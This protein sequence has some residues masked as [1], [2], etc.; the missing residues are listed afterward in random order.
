MTAVLATTLPEVE[1]TASRLTD[2]TGLVLR[3]QGTD[4]GGWTS[5][6]V[7]RS[8][9]EAAS[10]WACEVSER[11]PGQTE[12]WPIKPGDRCEVILD[13]H[14]VITGWVDVYSVA[15][16]AHTHR[17]EVRGRSLTEDAV[18]SSVELDAGQLQGLT[19]P[20]IAERV[21]KPLGIQIAYNAPAGEALPDVQIQQ[22]ET[23]HALLERLSRLPGVLV[24]DDEGG[25]LVFTRPGARRAA[26]KLVQGQNIVAASA[27]F[28]WTDRGS[29]YIVKAHNT[30]P[31][32]AADWDP[33]S[34]D[35]GDAGAGD[36]GDDGGTDPEGTPGTHDT[37]VAPSGSATDPAVTRHRPVII[38]GEHLM[39]A[40][41]A[42]LR[43]A[44]E[45]ARRIGRSQRAR[46][47]VQ[48][49]TQPDGTLW[50]AGDSVPITAPF[51]VGLDASLVIAAVEFLKDDAGSRTELELTLPGAFMASAQEMDQAAK[52]ASGDSTDT[53]QAWDEGAAGDA[54]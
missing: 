53:K 40:K 33:A 37:L 27:E 21:A 28:D 3:I 52:P 39:D 10:A 50:H 8:V 6:R 51:L 42:A 25:R 54:P 32:D 16:D 30:N 26:G 35:G 36:A 34:G 17:V 12:P 9:E 5:L 24:S 48:G 19:L 38:Y 29:Q 11:W 13:G 22:G 4:Y 15:F 1:V 14:L 41:Q 23:V 18:D 44:Y 7:R 2:A 20:Q 43:A 45:R 46:V 47:T 31:N 49:W